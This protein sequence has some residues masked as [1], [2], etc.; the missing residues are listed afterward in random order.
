MHSRAERPGPG[1]RLALTAPRGKALVAVFSKTGEQYN[2]GVIQ[3][4]NTMIV[5]K[6]IAAAAGA[7]LFEIRPS[8]LTPKAMTKPPTS[9]K[10]NCARACASNW[11]RTKISAPTTPS[12]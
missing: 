9:P 4:G 2:V 12:F 6:M 8:K 5:A 1:R 11:R 7:D 10:R 3:E